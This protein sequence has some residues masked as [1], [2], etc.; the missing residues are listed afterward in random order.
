MPLTLGTRLGPYDIVGTLGA[1]GMGEVYRARDT[2]LDRDVAIKVLPDLFIADPDRVA[3]FQREAKTLAALNHANIGSIYGLEEAPGITAL[4]LELVEGPTLADRIAEGPLPLDEALAIARQVIDALE[5]AHDQGIIHRDLKP[6]NIKLR[7]DGAVKVLDF[8]LARVVSGEGGASATG[9]PSA[10]LSPTITNAAGLTGVGMLLGTAAYMAPEQARGRAVDKRADIW[11]FGCVLYEM[12]SARRAFG[13]STGAGASPES[14]D[15]ADDVSDTLAAVLRADPDW[16]ALP[17][18]TPATVRFALT[19]CLEKNAR[20]RLRDIADFRMLLDAPAG[21][22]V[23][24][25]E[26][27]RAPEG[28]ARRRPV[29]TSAGAALV[30]VIASGVTWWLTRPTP[31]PLPVTRLAMTHTGGTIGTPSPGSDVTVSPDG[32]R[33]VYVA[34]LPGAAPQLHIRPL[35]ALNAATLVTQGQT[36]P[37]RTPAFSPDGAW[38]A[39]FED[40]SLNKVTAAGG[41]AVAV[42]TVSG[43]TRGA[44]WGVDGHVVFATNDLETG[45]MRVSAAGGT[46]EVLTKPDAAKAEA[47]HV[48]PDVLPGGKAV[49]FTIAMKRQDEFQIGLLDLATRAWRVIIPGGSEPRFAASGHI[50]YGV[51]GTLRAVAFDLDR[52]EVT[53]DPVPVLDGVE[54]KGGS[55][56]FS[57]SAT[58]TLVYIP[59]SARGT[60]ARTLLWVDRDGREEPVG[61]PLGSYGYPQVSPD[62][63]RILVVKAASDGSFDLW[64][65]ELGRGTLERLTSDAGIDDSAVW[66]PDGK[67][68]A[69]F[70]SGRD[71]GPGMHVRS[72]DFTGTVERLTTGNHRPVA[73]SPDGS[74]IVFVDLAG[75]RTTPYGGDLRVV[76]LGQKPEVTSL[77]A[78]P[79]TE[80]NASISP[81]GRWLAFETN[82]TGQSE[83]MVR[84]FP[85]VDSG[86]WR[87]SAAGGSDP[88]WS[89]DGRTLHYRAERTMMAVAVRAGSPAE[90]GRPEMRFQGQFYTSAGPRMF[91][92]APGGRF[93]MLRVEREEAARTHQVIVVQNWFEELKRLVPAT[94]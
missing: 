20:R 55:T 37:L 44:H 73:W 4:V 13:P 18:D 24:P 45:L 78:T 41:P 22:S 56:N 93:L 60:E 21:R 74:R 31:T 43:Q 82:E 19:R 69:Y 17:S 92:L 33:V 35:D 30:A 42:A 36:I 46:P 49:L 53:S 12:L 63:K 76:T 52:L 86:R 50:V 72:S 57:L 83:V 25:A 89:H 79:A 88:V 16:T 65:Y 11:A 14:R 94:R 77:I 38:V 64:I 28:S 23:A 71:G 51:G 1:G 7:A 6:A 47:D 87:I 90:W 5:A 68:I 54:M 66:S 26:A 15:E 80:D 70:S 61:A 91:D 59:G 84:P 3:R 9:G 62:G 29:A 32:R 67:R 10:S 39:Y 27:A 75:A 8:G 40:T 85:D 81:D 34:A 48:Y 58:G 2:K